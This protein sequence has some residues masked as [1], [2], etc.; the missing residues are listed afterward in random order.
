MRAFVRRLSWRSAAVIGV[1]SVIAGGIAYAAIPDSQGVYTACAHK[2]TGALRLI[3]PAV[4]SC[5]QS[6]T[7]VTW[8]KQ[9]Q[10]GP[11]GP[12]GPQG[13]QGVQGPAG[14]DGAPGGLAG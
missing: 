13:P 10:T 7:Q 8:V 9:G 3:D 14:A 12:V 1:F 5:S 11:Q 6:E 2:S 4:G